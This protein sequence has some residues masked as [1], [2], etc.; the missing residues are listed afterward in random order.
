MDELEGMKF[1]KKVPKVIFIYISK[2]C[3]SNVKTF[4]K[5]QPERIK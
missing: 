3:T 5:K 1:E 2:M 4:C